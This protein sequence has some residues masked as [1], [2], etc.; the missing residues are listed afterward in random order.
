MNA[1]DYEKLTT[2]NRCMDDVVMILKAWETT[3]GFDQ[4]S[5]ELYTREAEQLKAS[6]NRYVAEVM[7]RIADATS[8][9][10]DKGR[11]EEHEEEEP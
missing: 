8:V 5:V 9:R 4:G 3:S 1:G 6:V 10:L 11:P 2:F 7:I